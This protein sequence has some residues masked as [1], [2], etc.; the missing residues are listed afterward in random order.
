M[1]VKQGRED[2]R[3]TKR[4]PHPHPQ[5]HSHILEPLAGKYL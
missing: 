4:H 5:S 3:K 1:E 2:R